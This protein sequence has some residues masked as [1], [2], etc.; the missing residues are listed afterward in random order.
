MCACA[1]GDVGMCACACGD[2]GMCA[3]ACG[4]VGMCA[5]ACGDVGMCTCACGDVGWDSPHSKNLKKSQCT[6]LFMAAYTMRDG[7]YCLS[8]YASLTLCVKP[9]FEFHTVII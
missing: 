2:V 7:Y 9:K 8:L 6:P 1:C 3:C 5:C 4:D